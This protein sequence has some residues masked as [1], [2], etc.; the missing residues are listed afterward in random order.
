MGELLKDYQGVVWTA[1]DGR[2]FNLKTL[3][4]EWTRKH[5]GEVKENPKTTY[6]SG[7]SNSGKKA[8]GSTTSKHSSVSVSGGSKRVQDSNDTFTDLGIGGRDI[9]LECYFIGKEH[10]EKANTFIKALGL[11]GKSRL[12]LV[13]GDELTVNVLSFTVKNDLTKNTNSTV[14]TVNFH[15]TSKTT[16]PQSQR[17][18]TKEIKASAEEAK[19][20]IAQ[21]LSDTV[22]SI[23]TPTRMSNF[24][25]NF[26]S[27]MDTVSEGLSTASNVSL[28]SIMTDIVS[29]TPASNMYTMAS[30]LGIVMYNAASVANNLKSEVMGFS[31]V[32]NGSIFGQWS[33]LIS[34]FVSNS[35][36]SKN[37]LTVDEID[38]L[39]INDSSAS[40]AII[41]LSESLIE[42]DYE[43]RAEAVEAAKT[44]KELEQTWTEHVEGELDKVSELENVLIRDNSLTDIVN[45][46]ASEIL[47]RSYKLK[48]EKTITLTEDTTIIDIA[49]GY[50]YDDF[51]ENPDDT[52]DYLIRTNGF[53]DDDFFL[54]KRGTEVKLYV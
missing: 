25:G 9:T 48:V 20:N 39:R 51:K 43:T 41:S 8:K 23:D 47:D 40:I 54:L 32:P 21:D 31:L 52:I 36:S 28:N 30:Q 27:M 22:D 13:F 26:S 19:T 5:I 42:K 34:G 46:S 49:Y 29:Q 10:N 3:V 1:P 16:Y 45:A 18:K 35:S 17:S 44:L 11:T 24:S 14:V 53:S 50:Y 4:N 37:S 33:S 12:K 15:E 7:V 38:N 6:S 2:S